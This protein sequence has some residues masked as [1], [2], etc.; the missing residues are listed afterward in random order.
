M[1]GDG[2][3]RLSTIVE[4][5]LSTL[6]LNKQ[7]EEFE[8]LFLST[9]NDKSNSVLYS[10]GDA[11]QVSEARD[12]ENCIKPAYRLPRMKCLS[13]VASSVILLAS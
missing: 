8:D 6:A 7:L 1:V 4:R 3:P 11:V 10:I 2:C 9:M 13:W 12:D 5:S